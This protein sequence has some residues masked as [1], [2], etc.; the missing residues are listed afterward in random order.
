MSWTQEEL[1]HDSDQFFEALLRE[2]RGARESV[3]FETYIYA[4]DD[5]GRRVANELMAAARRGVRVRAT[6]DGVGSPSFATRFLPLLEAQGA[7]A[8]IYHPPPWSA[9]LHPFRT[10]DSSRLVGRFLHYLQ[11]LNRRNHRKVCVIDGRAA[12]VGSANVSNC[13]LREHSG[14]RAW[15]DTGARVEGPDVPLLGL[16]FEKAWQESWAPR[17]RR[18]R[19]WI[20]G[21]MTEKKL[22]EIRRPAQAPGSLVRLNHT[23]ALRQAAYREFLRRILDAKRRVWITN[24]YFVPEG[25]LLRVLAI[26]ALSGVDVRILVPSKSDVFF[27][28]WAASAYYGSLLKSGVRIFEYLPTILHAKNFII[29]DWASIG[30]NNLN[31]R[32]LI[33]DLEVDVVLETRESLLSLERQFLIDLTDSR[34]VSLQ[35]WRLTPW[36]RRLAVRIV[37][38]FRHWI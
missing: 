38:L 28:K 24:P 23:R 31:H 4:D 13:H 20:R 25:L 36:Y 12:W 21:K 15:R 5:S 17:R 37:L 30:S 16:A 11:R 10:H 29:D 32:S 7:E 19:E 18:V 26:S 2:I 6:I 33:H 1:F 27:M 14:S 3:E 9:L 22:S 35:E 34:E 8:R